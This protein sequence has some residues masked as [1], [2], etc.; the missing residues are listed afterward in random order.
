MTIRLL[1][2]GQRSGPIYQTIAD[3][4]GREIETGRM[5]PGSR[6]PTQRALARQ[7]V[8]YATG[9]PLEADDQAHIERIIAGIRNKNYGFKSLIQAIVQSPLFQNK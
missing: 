5:K 2:R 8:T 9:A 1:P 6:L 7:L 4:I 3:Q